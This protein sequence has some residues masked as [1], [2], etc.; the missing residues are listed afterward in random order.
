MLGS[1]L[2]ANRG[3]VAVR[4]IRTARTLGIRTIAVYSQ[5]DEGALWTRLADQAVCI[6][7]ARPQES[8]LNARRIVAAATESGATA[9]H[10]GYGLLSEDA[11]F[12]QAVQDAGMAFV[13]PRPET[14]AALGD[15]ISARRAA[16]NSGLAILPGSSERLDGGEEALAF[17]QAIGWP[18]VVKARFGGG[19]RGMR[20]ARDPSEL[21]TAMA[22]AARE[23]SIAFDRP[24]IYLEALLERPRHVEVQIL[25]DQHGNVVHLGDRD[26]SVQRRH[27]KVI[28]EAP[29]PDLPAPLRRSMAEAAVALARSVGYAGVGTVEF[30][31]DAGRRTFY[32][33]EMNTR[34]QV[35]HGVTELITGL[36][37]VAW[38]LRVA[39]GEPLDFRQSDV[40]L[41][42]HAMQARVAAEDPWLE[43]RPT[44]GKVASLDLPGGPG[45]RCDFGLQAGDR[46]PIYY[47]SVL[48]K[49]LAWGPDRATARSRLAQALDDLRVDGLPTSAGFLATLLQEPAFIDAKHHTRSLEEDWLPKALARI[50]DGPPPASSIVRYVRVPWGG[51]ETEV[52]IHSTPTLRM[53]SD[54]AAV[55]GGRR[56]A[57]HVTSID[58][59]EATAPM[60]A[61]VGAVPAAVGDMVRKG[62]AIVVL[63]AM[64]MELTVRAPRDGAVTAVFVRTGEVV[65]SGAVLFRLDRQ[66][67]V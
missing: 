3:E 43:F 34:L 6:G 37:L 7:G 64:K 54:R 48:G 29:A 20:V 65:R 62:D 32:F 42:G 63:E 14:I 25:G 51:S 66:P 36:D 40:R 21:S 58:G 59:N 11:G 13:G 67:G 27:Q 12:A 23:A 56:A 19:G 15:K 35:E 5:A 16:V 9:V 53:T 52:A 61:V 18:L 46:V 33:L 31:V 38:Q 39:A 60:D 22:A 17:A 55:P 24:D 2:I 44:H 4:I 57:T 28:E 8:Y 49:V 1:V 50:P 10:P 30:L 26:C 41:A 45:V 47:D